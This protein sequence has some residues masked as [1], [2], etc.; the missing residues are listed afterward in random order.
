MNLTDREL[1]MKR[2]NQGTSSIRERMF[3]DGYILLHRSTVY[4]WSKNRKISEWREKLITQWIDEYE[5]KL[6]AKR[7]NMLTNKQ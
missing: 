7:N 6:I 3:N 4:E 1:Q 2:C 5:I